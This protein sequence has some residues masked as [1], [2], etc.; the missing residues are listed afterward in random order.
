MAI[1]ILIPT[2]LRV[3]TDNQD[4]VEA[5]GST[6]GELLANMTDQYT[7]LRKHL[8]RE[9][10]KLRSFVNI[11]LNDD[12]I[13]YLDKEKTS[14]TAEDTVSIVPSVAGGGCL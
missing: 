10:G 4:T 11:Y 14:V 5:E 7:E 1:Q 13:R 8:Y 2:P 9:D 12:D 6:V 3:Y